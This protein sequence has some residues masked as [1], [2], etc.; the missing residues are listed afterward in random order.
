MH[1]KKGK[2]FTIQVS[3]IKPDLFLGKVKEIVFMDSIEGS[4]VEEVYEQ[5][6]AE[7]QF[8]CKDRPDLE[9]VAINLE[10]M[11][12]MNTIPIKMKRPVL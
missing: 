8:L 11:P 4:D 3:Q 1:S 5:L 2:M 6:K 10:C 12:L 7:I 9:N